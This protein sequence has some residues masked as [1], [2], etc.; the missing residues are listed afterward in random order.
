MAR[1]CPAFWLAGSILWDGLTCL[2]RIQGRDC[3]RNLSS[4]ADLLQAQILNH[5][6]GS[7][8]QKAVLAGCQQEGSEVSSPVTQPRWWL[9]GGTA[10]GFFSC[11]RVEARVGC[12]AVPGHREVRQQVLLP[13][14]GKDKHIPATSLSLEI[15]TSGSWRG[16][17]PGN[18]SSTWE[19]IFWGKVELPFAG[20][21]LMCC[22]LDECP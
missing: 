11:L 8:W 1:G 7:L 6:L 17:Q 18:I 9:S 16:S 15:P 13:E 22:G 3:L 12:T 5:S 4:Q 2:E 10:G 19:G 20:F 14:L 21:I